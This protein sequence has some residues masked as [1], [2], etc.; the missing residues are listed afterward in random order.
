M[1]DAIETKPLNAMEAWRPDPGYLTDGDEAILLAIRACAAA[2]LMARRA[3]HELGVP[4]EVEAPN[5]DRWSVAVP[6]AHH[7]ALCRR[8]V[9]PIVAILAYLS[10]A[11]PDVPDAGQ[12]AEAAVEEFAS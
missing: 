1:L 9:H 7:T 8:P 2:G 12:I 11:L 6:V 10:V 4:T 5:I 3:Q